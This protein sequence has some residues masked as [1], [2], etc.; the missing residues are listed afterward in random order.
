MK[1][2]GLTGGWFA[3][4][5]FPGPGCLLPA[6]PLPRAVFWETQDPS[7]GWLLSRMAE[8]SVGDAVTDE[9][10]AWICPVVQGVSG[11]AS[12]ETLVLPMG[13]AGPGERRVLAAGHRL[14]SCCRCQTGLNH[15]LSNWCPPG[16]HFS[17]F[18]VRPHSERGRGRLWPPQGEGQ[19]PLLP[20]RHPPPWYPH[21]PRVILQPD[22][23]LISRGWG[24]RGGIAFWICMWLNGKRA[25][26]RE[27]R[28]GLALMGSE[29]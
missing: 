21:C 15:S 27:R 19:S 10:V 8:P 18:G 29:Y 13:A 7:Q 3:I 16:C 17:V 6:L 24:G 25:G 22:S 4:S 26:R 5:C 1:S 14:C 11:G 12:Q 20:S 2:T 23:I 9:A 28:A